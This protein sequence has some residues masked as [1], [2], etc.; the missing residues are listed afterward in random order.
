MMAFKIVQCEVRWL[1]CVGYSGNE[2]PPSTYST[3]GEYEDEGDACRAL[4]EAGMTRTNICGY[5]TGQS[6][7]AQGYVKRIL[8]ELP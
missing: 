3:I 4:A 2:L 7:Y 5:W 8:K 6:G 1:A